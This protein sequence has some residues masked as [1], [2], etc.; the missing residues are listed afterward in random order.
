MDLSPVIGKAAHTP[1]D[2][3]NQPAHYPNGAYIGVMDAGVGQR[4][5]FSHG[6]SPPIQ[7]TSSNQILGT[8]TVGSQNR[9]LKPP[10]TFLELDVPNLQILQIGDIPGM[11]KLVYRLSLGQQNWPRGVIFAE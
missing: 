3:R 1:L 5:V 10:P 8:P 7:N 6:G 11:S 4:W 9:P 2:A